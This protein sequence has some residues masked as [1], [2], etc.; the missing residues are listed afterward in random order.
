MDNLAEI[1]L[2]LWFVI[3]LAVAG[4]RGGGF[5]HYCLPVIPPLALIASIEISRA[6]QR[7]KTSSEKL[8]NLGRSAAITLVIFLCLWSNYSLYRNYAMYKLSWISHNEFLQNVYED[9]FASQ[10]I[11]NYL[12]THTE[13][14]DL[15]YLWSLHIGVYYYADRLPPI[16]ILWPTYVKRGSPGFNAP[17]NILFW[18]YPKRTVS[19]MLLDDGGPP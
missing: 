17:R 1:F 14:D 7:W 6:Y 3:S 13:P 16:D 5:P 4:L 2:I 12:K 18:I 11:S 15:I 19:P 9:G 10:Q 8:A